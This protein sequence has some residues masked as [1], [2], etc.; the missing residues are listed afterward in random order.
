MR[1]TEDRAPLEFT[2]PRKKQMVVVCPECKAARSVSVDCVGLICK[3]GNYFSTKDSLPESEAES[4]YNSI[5]T[6]NKEFT[7]LKANMERKAY[8]WR[9]E[10]LKKRKTGKTRSHEPIGD[11]GK[12][13]QRKWGRK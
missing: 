8:E 3:C 7:K 11:D 4:V 6:I 2:A 5:G 13:Q 1:F 10:Q 9:D 12:V